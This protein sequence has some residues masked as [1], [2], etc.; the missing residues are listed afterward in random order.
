MQAC[1]ASSIMPPLRPSR[2]APGWR[3]AR[4]YHVLSAPLDT[5]SPSPSRTRMAPATRR[6]R[7]GSWRWLIAPEL[8]DPGLMR[9]LAN[10][11]SLLE[12]PSSPVHRDPP[13][14]TALLVRRPRA[15]SPALF[16]KRPF[17]G[18][19]WQRLKHCWR[20]SRAVRAFR[21]ALQL[22]QW[23]IPTAKALAAGESRRWG[24]LHDSYLITEEVPGV[25]DWAQL[26][27]QPSG[28][29]SRTGIIR[30]LARLMALL[31]SAGLSH[32]D[33]ARPNFL[34]Q[35]R[36]AA[37]ASLILIDLDGVRRHWWISPRRVRRN[38]SH[39]VR[40]LLTSHRERIWFLA[41]Y[42]RARGDAGRS[43]ELGR[44][45][46]REAKRELLFGQGFRLFK[47]RTAGGMTWRVR[48]SLLTPG[49]ET[50]LQKPDEFLATARV[51]KPSRSSAVSAGSGLVLKRDNYRKWSSRIGD[52]F[53][54][55]RAWRS[56]HKGCLLEVAGVATARPIAA[57]EVR[58]WGLVRRSYLLMEEISAASSLEVWQGDWAL[59]IGRVA[60]L[61]ARL[62]ESGFSHRDLKGGNVI[63][64]AHDQPHLIDLDGLRIHHRTADRTAAADL[65][66]L[67]R[68]SG[69]WSRPL[70]R[71]A[72]LRFLIAYCRCRKRADWRWWWRAVTSQRE[73]QEKR[74]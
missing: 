49:A 41:Q 24:W 65:A 14:T 1:P 72:R 16:I 34:V 4:P 11:E 18:T 33:P 38:L 64:D 13:R 12:P 5:D 73:E 61:L 8:S 58:A 30:A 43:R 28:G 44:Q 40:R 25:C 26:E 74:D 2:T 3:G 15:G 7:L 59:G 71:T 52:A 69:R 56:F 31:H 9:A 42:A 21:L 46:F 67:E 68:S 60:R 62:H 50:I 10:P 39:A 66:R 22:Q 36:G 32:G 35:L 27:A 51:L 17:P 23:G 47:T 55:S 57:A 37:Q 19:V 54:R 29:R 53:R 20:P 48:P 70:S 45:L 6:L 63:F